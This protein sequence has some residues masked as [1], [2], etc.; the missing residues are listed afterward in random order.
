LAFICQFDKKKERKTQK[1]KLNQHT[2]RQTDRQRE[3]SGRQQKLK[4]K[5]KQNLRLTQYRNFFSALYSLTD[6]RWS[7]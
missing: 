6:K 2:D 1:E 5:S 3:E 7:H 4:P